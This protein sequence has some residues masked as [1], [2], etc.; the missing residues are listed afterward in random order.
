MMIQKFLPISASKT[1]VHYEVYKNTHS[2]DED[3]HLIADM[4]A[5]VMS[6][7]KALCNT[8]QRN[9]QRGVYV[10]GELH[11]K[12][13][14]APLHFQQSVREVVTQH[15]LREAKDGREIWPARQVLTGGDVLQEDEDLCKALQCG[16]PNEMLAW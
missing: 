1:R 6:E 3:F 11:P 13:E 9:L 5:R 12:W 4:Y 16:K 7:D 14:K 10:S 2:S 8:A 15:C